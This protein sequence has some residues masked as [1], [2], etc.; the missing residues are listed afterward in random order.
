MAVDVDDFLGLFEPD[1]LVKVKEVFEIEEEWKPT[2]LT[3]K[4]RTVTVW[5]FELFKMMIKQWM[6]ESGWTKQQALDEF[7]E[8]TEFA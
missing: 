8:M 7:F 2:V 6:K 4:G 1:P 3:W 5:D